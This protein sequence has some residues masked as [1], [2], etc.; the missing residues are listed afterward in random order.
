MIY[1]SAAEVTVTHTVTLL[2]IGFRLHQPTALVSRANTILM[3]YQ[4][5]AAYLVGRLR[6]GVLAAPARQN[7]LMPAAEAKELHREL[8]VLPSIL[9]TKYP[10]DSC[11]HC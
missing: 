11:R 9:S 1:I 5:A 8:F 10:I 7:T 2:P 3:S 4:E 6:L